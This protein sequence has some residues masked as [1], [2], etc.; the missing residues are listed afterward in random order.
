[1]EKHM[2]SAKREPIRSDQMADVI[3]FLNWIALIFAI[4]FCFF[5]LRII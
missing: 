3:D 4:I 1:M 2:L 5:L